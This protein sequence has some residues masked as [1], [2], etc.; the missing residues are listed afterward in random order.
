MLDIGGL[1]IFFVSLAG[2]IKGR[3]LPFWIPQVIVFAAFSLLIYQGVWKR[4][5]FALIHTAALWSALSWM[6]GHMMEMSWGQG[7][8]TQVPSRIL[9]LITPLV[10]I[11]HQRVYKRFSPAAGK[12]LELTPT[13]SS[14]F[15][16]RWHFRRKTA[17]KSEAMR[18][19]VFDLGEEINFQNK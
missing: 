6:A 18:L 16:E 7:I 10:V 5:R 11:A 9:L 8:Q 1:V 17:S 15:K 4:S 2:A 14:Q 13:E 3:G 12:K 19:I